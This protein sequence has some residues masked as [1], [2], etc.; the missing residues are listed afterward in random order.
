MSEPGFSP[1][2]GQGAKRDYTWP[3]V[4][5][6]F[7]AFWI[8][9]LMVASPRAPEEI[10]LS[11]P[12][13]P[14]DY[15]WTLRDL[16]DQPVKFSNFAGKA[17]FLNVWATWCPPCVGEMPSIAR[18]AGDPSFQGK[19]IEFVCVAIDDSIETVRQF[20]RDKKWPMTVLHATALPGVF[21]TEGIPATFVIAPD[22]R[23][24]ATTIGA[25]DW[26]SP[27]IIKSLQ[28]VAAIPPKTPAPTAA[29]AS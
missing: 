2:P 24:V 8:V 19:N 20:V 21:L 10:D 6:L 13:K 18:L 3:I 14:A 5:G 28:A 26:E 22:G 23:V 7:L 9:Y 11:T 12:G 17:V 25:R 29:P 16:N 27:E 4:V 1:A 15:N